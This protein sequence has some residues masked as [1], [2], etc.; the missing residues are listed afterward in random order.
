MLSASL[1]LWILIFLCSCE[2]KEVQA[3]LATLLGLHGMNS[4][5]SVTSIASFAANT[6][7]ETA[8]KQ[9]C[10]E[11]YRIG[12]TEDIIQQEKDKILE[13]LRSQGMVTS[14]QIG[15]KDGGDKDQKLEMAYKEYCKDLYR[16]GFTDDMIQKDKIL[17]ILRSRGVASSQAGGSSNIGDKGQVLEAIL[18]YAQSL[19]Y[20][21]IVILTQRLCLHLGLALGLSMKLSCA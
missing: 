19:T 10:K 17:G 13:I 5:I 20:E 21:Q 7:T 4:G 6:N 1:I 8:Y 18:T 12:V 2:Y 14:S 9:F 11:L 3:Q 15:K 16:I